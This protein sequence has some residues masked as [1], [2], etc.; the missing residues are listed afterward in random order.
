MKMFA[1]HE[2]AFVLCCFAILTPLAVSQEVN[3]TCLSGATPFPLAVTCPLGFYCPFNS[4]P[5][6]CSPTPEC[7]IMR[8]TGAFCELPQGKELLLAWLHT[9]S[10]MIGT[11]EPLV[12]PAGSYCP[13]PAEIYACP[14]G[15]FCHTG[16][17]DPIKCDATSSCPEGT[18]RQRY[19][20][21]LVCIQS[22]CICCWL[23]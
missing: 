9:N 5:T 10:N 3:V 19:F 12:C 8:L 22:V 13:T 20:G 1:Q 18:K 11:T 4:P 23:L 7:S 15:H 17:A 14:E 2:L 21:G 6:Y 16:T